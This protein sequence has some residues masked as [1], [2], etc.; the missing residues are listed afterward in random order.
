MPNSGAKDR[1]AL[2]LSEP[3]ASHPPSPRLSGQHFR[4]TVAEPSGFVDGSTGLA[5]SGYAIDILET[6]TKPD[7]ADLS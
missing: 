5:F 4:F 2:T 6:I 3:C 7:L 1:T